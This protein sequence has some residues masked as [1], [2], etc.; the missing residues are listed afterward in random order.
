MSAAVYKSNTNIPTASW[1]IVWDLLLFVVGGGCGILAYAHN[2]VI[3]EMG[4]LFFH[5]DR[6]CALWLQTSAKA[7]DGAEEGERSFSIYCV[8]KFIFKVYFL[9]GESATGVNEDFN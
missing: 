6:N 7:A 9:R 3:T 2:A 1:L 5:V 8:K 4:I